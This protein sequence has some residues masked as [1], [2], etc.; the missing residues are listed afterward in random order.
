M[1][2]MGYGGIQHVSLLWLT[3]QNLKEILMLYSASP[4]GEE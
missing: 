2:R 1:R 4:L 3:F